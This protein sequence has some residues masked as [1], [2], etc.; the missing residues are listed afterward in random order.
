MSSTHPTYSSLLEIESI[1]SDGYVNGETI[2]QRAD[3]AATSAEAVFLATASASKQTRAETFERWRARQVENLVASRE[4][5][6][7]YLQGDCPPDIA[8]AYRS[9]LLA[10]ES[11]TAGIA[12]VALEKE[13]AAEVAA[14]ASQAKLE[15]ALRKLLADADPNHTGV[16]LM[17]TGLVVTEDGQLKLFS[18]HLAAH[19]FALASG[20]RCMLANIVYRPAFV[21]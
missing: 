15:K 6:A 7:A 5:V 21:G 3:A 10:L 11:L 1:L 13:M 14:S 19:D 12:M 9:G 2:E 16:E 8:M 4:D 20:M 17:P 18:G